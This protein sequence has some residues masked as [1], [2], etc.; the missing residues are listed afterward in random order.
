MVVALLQYFKDVLLFYFRQG[1]DFI[2]TGNFAALYLKMLGDF[3][4]LNDR[5]FI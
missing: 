4:A 5:L 3:Y 2:G 1:T